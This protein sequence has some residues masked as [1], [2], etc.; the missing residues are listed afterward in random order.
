MSKII[1]HWTNQIGLSWQLAQSD[2]MVCTN[3]VLHQNV[4][5]GLWYSY[6]AMTDNWILYANWQMEMHLGMSLQHWLA[7]ESAFDWAQ[8]KERRQADGVVFSET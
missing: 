7:R 5:T 2:L 3:A 4:T 1:E 6:T 8:G